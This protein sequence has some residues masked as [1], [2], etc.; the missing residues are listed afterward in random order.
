ME[1]NVVIVM[2]STILAVAL[3]VGVIYIT[4]TRINK[5]LVGGSTV[6]F[7]IAILFLIFMR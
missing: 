6:L 4:R 2:V 7:L 5:W 3:N 1:I